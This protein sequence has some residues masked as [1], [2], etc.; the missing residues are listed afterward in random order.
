MAFD[1]KMFLA[2]FVEEAR[3]HVN[4]LNDGLVGLEKNPGDRETINNIFRSAHTIKGSAKMMKLTPIAEVSHKLE[5]VLG[6]LRDG[7]I[8][9]SGN[10]W[11]LLFKAL[12][13]VSGMI[14]NVADGVEISADN[15]ALCEELGK[16]AEGAEVQ[17]LN[18]TP[19]GAVEGAVGEASAVPAEAVESGG[20]K[21]PGKAGEAAGA[22]SSRAPQVAA[23][24][25]AGEARAKAAET[26]RVRAE[27]L[28]E[29]IKLLGEL[30]S[31]QNLT[32]KKVSNLKGLELAMKRRPAA[33]RGG[34]DLL[35]SDMAMMLNLG[36]LTADLKEECVSQELLVAELQ[37]KALKLRM[38]PLSIIFDPL[39]RMARDFAR[40]FGK[41]VEFVVEGGEIELDR[42]MTEKLGDPLVH[43][44]RNA[45]DHGMETPGERA[46]AGKPE[47][48]LIRISASCEAG[49]V[50]LEIS[51]DGRGISPGKIR[52]KALR[53]KLYSEEELGRMSGP[54]LTDLIFLPGFSTSEIITDMSG[55][56]VGMDVVRNNIVEDLKGG[57]SIA[58]KE[59]LGTTFHVRLPLTLAIARALI[60]RVSGLHFGI[61]SHYVVEILK[62][63][64]SEMIAVVDKKAMR[65]REEF[66]PVVKL[67]ALLGLPGVNGNGN[68][69]SLVITLMMGS[70]KLGVAVDG[71]S[72]EEN[73]VIKSLPSH[74]KN[75]QM[76]SGVTVSGD[77]EIISILHVPA[78]YAKSREMMDARR[79]RAA[80]EEKRE[81]SIL[82]V[83][84]SINTREIEKSILEAYGYRV[85]LAGDGFEALEML[86]K[87]QY[88]LVVTDIEMPR[89]DGFSL[90]ARLREDAAYKE[91]PIIIVTSLEKEEDKK[92]GIKVG[93]N[94]YIV[95]GSFDQTN[96]IETVRNLVG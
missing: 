27:K 74:M 92:R 14:A 68:D 64:E 42:K 53:R 19:A 73:V 43:M 26:V 7:R 58:S 78:L 86:R 8:S 83:D 34:Q 47:K 96:L 9:Y 57:L 87:R 23:E 82:V 71:L 46:A 6:A 32:R 51:D 45:M 21:E 93:A 44:L 59:G 89:L 13:S 56:G 50:L 61:T 18:A 75:V 95:K 80:R 49:N 4:S 10:L 41:E 5:D 1:M 31:R 29:I 54:E 79:P 15:A 36:K 40:S 63:A 12:D 65:V 39:G 60:V 69:E 35:Q 88:D 81:I 24:K 55:R 30:V 17:P 66:I 84:D 38:V 20:A 11:D 33:D 85:E 77:N 52:E 22:S 94:A 16:A 72:N 70:E 3:E 91:T 48:G 76:V 2:R 28:D 62:M 90:T 37:E 67:S 25:Q